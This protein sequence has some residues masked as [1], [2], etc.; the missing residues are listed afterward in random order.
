M[1]D[2][3]V[4]NRIILIFSMNINYDKVLRENYFNKRQI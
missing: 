1:Y 3:N 4:I 2:E